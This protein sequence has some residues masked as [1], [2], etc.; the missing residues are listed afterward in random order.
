MRLNSKDTQIHLE[1]L[2]EHKR[3]D[4]TNLFLL[5]THLK[6]ELSKK[7][8]K[9]KKNCDLANS[10]EDNHAYLV[11]DD[12]T[13]KV[14]TGK[15]TNNTWV[16]GKLVTAPTHPGTYTANS[17]AAAGKWEK[18]MHDFKLHTKV[19]RVT[20]EFIQKTYQDS[21]VLLDLEDK[22]GNIKDDPITIIQHLR[23]LVPKPEKE[24]QILKLKNILNNKEYNPDE[25]VQRYLKKLQITRKNLTTLDADPGTPKM[26]HQAICDFEKH[27]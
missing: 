25:A 2:I 19:H 8:T 9:K 10:G 22:N 20:I 27:A 23:S 7:E 3:F 11:I 4:P 12:G 14:I 1:G 16:D 5:Q 24:Q 18:E 15:N 13:W 21:G 26:I 6:K 17:M